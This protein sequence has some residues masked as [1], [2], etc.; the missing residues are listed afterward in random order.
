MNPFDV[1]AQA[2][3]IHEAVN[4]AAAERRRRLEAVRAQVREHDVSRWIEAQLEALE[5][6]GAR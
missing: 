1:E 5:V 4:M 3:A 6:V 2:E